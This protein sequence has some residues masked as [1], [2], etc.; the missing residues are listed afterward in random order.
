MFLVLSSGL[1]ISGMIWAFVDIS[2]ILGRNEALS[3]HIS[4]LTSLELIQKHVDVLMLFCHTPPAISSRVKEP[5][6]NSQYLAVNT[7]CS[8]MSLSDDYVQTVA[9]PPGAKCLLTDHFFGQLNYSA[10]FIVVE[11]R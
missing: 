1:F 3:Y 8:H 2:E 11:I 4:L 10:S 5:T 7:F 9:E 6:F